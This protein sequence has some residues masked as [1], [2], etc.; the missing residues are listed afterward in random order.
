MDK[1]AK[2][3]KKQIYLT[4]FKPGQSGNPNGRPKGSR[5]RVTL[6]AEQLVDGAA[7]DV[8]NKIIEHAMHG[9]P[10]ALKL[11]MERI[12]PVRKERPTPFQLPPVQTAKDLPVA[13]ASIAQAVADGDLTIS[14]AA[15]ASR[16]FESYARAVEVTEIISRIDALEREKVSEQ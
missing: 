2:T 15:E 11:L 9:E 13:M 14:E 8:V 12:L 16:L 4:R 7:E 5:H 1:P 6:L 3:D 10:N